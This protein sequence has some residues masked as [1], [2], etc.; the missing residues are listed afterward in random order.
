MEIVLGIVILVGIYSFGFVV[1][2]LV[3]K[4]DVD[5]RPIAGEVFPRVDVL[6]MPH[7]QDAAHQCGTSARPSAKPGRQSAKTNVACVAGDEKREKVSGRIAL[8]TRS[9]TKKAFI[10]SEI[11][12]RKY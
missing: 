12:K 7:E 1:K 5:A 10:Y 3:S 9:E 2:G 11:F 6:E 4:P 8:G